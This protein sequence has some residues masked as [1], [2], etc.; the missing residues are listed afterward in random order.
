MAFERVGVRA[1]IE[2]L[3]AFNRDARLINKRLREVTGNVKKLEKESRTLSKS[4]KLLSPG[5]RKAGLALSGLAVAGGAFLA[6]ATQLAA[7]VETLGVV[8][9]TLGKNVGKTKDEI[10]AL[11]KAVA[12]QGITLR[13]TRTAIALMI[14]SNIDLKFAVDLASEAQNAAVIAGVDSSEA[15]ERLVFTIT[16]GN[17]R[18]ARTLGLQVSFQ[19]AY[20][21][22]AKSLGI[23]TLALTQQQ[24]ITARTNE[25][26]RAGERIVG[27]YDAAMETAG[28]KVF[29]LNRHIEESTRIMGELFLPLFGD[30]VDLLTEFLKGIESASVASQR[31]AAATIAASTAV[32]ALS[33]A[34]LLFLSQ[35]PKLIAGLKVLGIAMSATAGAAGLLITALAGLVIV[36]IRASAENKILRATLRDLVGVVNESGLSFREYERRAFEAAEGTLAYSGAQ[37]LAERTGRDFF[38]ALRIILREQGLLNE[39]QLRAVTISESFATGQGITAEKLAIVARRAATAAEKVGDLASSEE[40]AAKRA[41][42]FAEAQQ[43]VVD[44]LQLTIDTDISVQF[45]DFR[46]E[47]DAINDELDDLEVEKLQAIADL[48]KESADDLAD[49]IDRIEEL[50]AR[51]SDERQRL[52][53][54]AGSLEVARL[55]L[56]EMNEEVSEASRLAAENRIG[57]IISDINS[58]KEAVGELT[59]ELGI[60]ASTTGDFESQQER[61]L[62]DLE[63]LYLDKMRGRVADLD[64]VT[65]AWSRQTAEIIFNL[66]TQRLGIDGFTR[67]ETQ[68]L[69]KLAGPEGLGLIDEAG[70]ALLESIDNA[71]AAMDSAGDQSVLFADDMASLATVINDPTIAADDLAA[72]IRDVALATLELSSNPTIAALLQRG[73]EPSGNFPGGFIRRQGGGSVRRGQPVRVGEGGEELFIPNQSGIIIPN[74]LTSALSSFLTAATSAIPIAGAGS[75]GAAAGGGT[76]EQNFN[77]TIHSAARTEQVA[78]DFNLLAL[79]GER[80]G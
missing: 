13:K 11:E 1:V 4:L 33:G 39:E 64:E 77:M 17:V 51:R 68:A 6:K 48:E 18:M 50:T 76:V 59:S 42:D 71:A 45:G 78:A 25:V 67:E 38:D 19:E 80:R 34:T 30:A 26:L 65:D 58:Q 31:G 72:A 75:P 24:K 10:R 29:S 40:D 28:K 8:T 32:A 3:G 43:K 47:V 53:E 35:L 54:L 16:S 36:G 66:A 61:A 9:V 23:T 46:E 60:L 73:F 2:G 12:D 37:R 5:F 57:A 44:Q 20:E 22:T 79:M 69:A 55:R 63:K 62:E 41:E 49:H 56:S 52:G 74:N 7:R 15:F 14:Q 21:R 27:A 70:V